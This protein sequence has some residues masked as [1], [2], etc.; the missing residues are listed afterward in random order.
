MQLCYLQQLLQT[1]RQLRSVGTSMPSPS[2]LDEIVKL[3]VL[4]QR[5]PEEIASIWLQYHEDAN[6]NRVAAVLQAEDWRK[7]SSRAKTK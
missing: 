4:E 5:T 6:K 1:G 7:F 2:T 3:G